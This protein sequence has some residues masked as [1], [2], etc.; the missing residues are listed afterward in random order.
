MSGDK[1]YLYGEFE[2]LAATE[3]ACL[4]CGHPTGNCSPDDQGHVRV[5][6]ADAFESLGHQEMFIVQEDIHVE[7]QISPF[8][9]A[10]VLLYA[11]GKAIP[12]S[13]AKKLGLL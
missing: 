6:G 2:F 1:N 8:T 11:K 7:K 5:I 12:V 3:T 9:K 10:K 13:E 4:V